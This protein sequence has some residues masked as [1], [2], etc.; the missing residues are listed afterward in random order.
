MNHIYHRYSFVAL[1][2]N[3]GRKI[4]QYEGSHIS[5]NFFI[6]YAQTNEIITDDVKITLS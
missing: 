2:W 3:D 5:Y 6:F 1:F 4:Y